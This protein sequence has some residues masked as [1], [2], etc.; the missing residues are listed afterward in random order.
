[1]KRIVVLIVLLSIL[2]L[3][4][5]SLANKP[6]AYLLKSIPIT[7]DS[8]SGGDY[9]LT[10]TAWMVTSSSSGGDHQLISRSATLEAGHGCCCTYLPCIINSP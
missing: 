7:Q 4:S 5:A 1:M 2:F 8:V 3:A 6:D 9:K 10:H